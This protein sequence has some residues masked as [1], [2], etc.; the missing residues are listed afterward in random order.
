MLNLDSSPP[1]LSGVLEEVT[2]ATTKEESD[3]GSSGHF[4]LKSASA[5]IEDF[6]REYERSK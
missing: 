1:E 4:G 6:V 2:T 5:D 3:D